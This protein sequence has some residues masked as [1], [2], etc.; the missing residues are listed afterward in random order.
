MIKRIL[1]VFLCFLFLSLPVS[2]DYESE[3]RAFPKTWQTALAKLHKK[4]PE[5]VF[6]AVPTGLSWDDVIRAETGKKSLVEKYY[7]PLLRNTGEGHYNPQKGTY[8][9]HDA[10]TWV[11]AS[12]ATVDYFMNPANFLNEIYIFQFEALSYDKDYHTLEGVE[13]IL[14]GTFMHETP[15]PH[16]GEEEAPSEETP[17]EETAIVPAE[18]E[19]G[20]LSE[21]EE[22]APA[23]EE[24]VAEEAEEK[25]PPKKGKTYA[26]IIMEAAEKS[27]VSPYYLASKIRTEIGISPSGSVTGKYPG[28]EGLYNFYNIGANDGKN[29]IANGLNWASLGTSYGRPWTTPE[30]SIINGA[31][32]IGELYISKGQNTMY[33]ERFNV[34]PDSGYALYT[35]QYMTNVYGAAGQAHSTYQGYKSAGTLADSKVFYIP[36]FEDMPAADTDV[37]FDAVEETTGTCNYTVVNVRSGPSVLHDICGKLA[38]GDTVTVLGGRRTDSTDRMHMLENPYWYEIEFGHVR[39]YVSTAYIDIL[40]SVRLSA[41]EKFS[42]ETVADRGAGRIYWEN[43]NSDIVSV[44]DRGVITAKQNGKALLRA[45]TSGGGMAA[46]CVS[47][48][49]TFHDM[50][51]H[52]AREVAEEVADMGLFNGTAEGVFSPEEL[53][54]RGMY[55]TVLSRLYK[56]F[57]GKL[58]ADISALPYLDI[59]AAV[60]YAE[61]VAWAYTN[62]ILP[63]EEGSM[64]S[65]SAPVTR[66]EMAMAAYLLADHMGKDTDAALSAG[67]PFTDFEDLSDAMQAAAAFCIENSIMRGMGNDTLSM[68]ET[69]TRAQVAQIAMNIYNAFK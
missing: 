39:G 30:A 63:F 47:V 6:V 13:L 12:A 3:L 60:W 22:S 11:S 14:D 59:D 18:G 54:T 61:A 7:S 58:H 66:G 26:E 9:Y 29:P 46:V 32:W 23:E 21:S 37:A 5:W 34:V 43:L 40:P 50:H 52:W 38:Y 27:G 36:T 57:G 10:S 53:M 49:G 19:E 25:T 2:A 4:Y 33:F 62:G 69:A 56:E 28:Y 8:T 64:F 31:I 17:S 48:S 44:N 55:I 51:D 24:T 20:D 1:S 15:I 45:F 65:P 16:P 41:G 35:H 42:L 67:K 68:E